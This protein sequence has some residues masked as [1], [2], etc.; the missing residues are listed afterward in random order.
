METIFSLGKERIPALSKN[1]LKN[2]GE[3]H[4]LVYI[5]NNAISALVSDN[6][7]DGRVNDV[8]TDYLY[9]VDANL[10]ANKANYY[11]KEDAVYE[12]K[13]TYR[14]GALEV[15]LTINYEHTGKDG[16]W[17]G[18]PY[19]DYLRVLVPE[20][21]FLHKA[22][23]KFADG[24]EFD[25]TKNVSIGSESGRRTFESVFEL[26]PQEKLT[27]NFNY[28]LPAA[29]SLDKGE[30][31][32][33]LYWQKQPGTVGMPIKIIFNQPFGKGIVNTDPKFEKEDG[34]SYTFSGYLEKDLKST[35]SLK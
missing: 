29:I 5:P 21:S 25:I 18:G 6:K 34:N 35:I 30:D 11:V 26:K 3:K 2:L 24:E 28:T 7:W 14:D 20:D 13:N 32:Y 19:T 8:K 16:A 12:I 31:I 1:L 9:V 22:T 4:L 17:P 10:G 33:P 27:L 15:N 23:S